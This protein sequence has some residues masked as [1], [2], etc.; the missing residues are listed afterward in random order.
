MQYPH[1]NPLAFRSFTFKE[2]FK[3]VCFK[4]ERKIYTQGIQNTQKIS[5]LPPNIHPKTSLKLSKKNL[6]IPY[7]LSIR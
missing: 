3:N 2:K 5:L 1:K 6:K 7:L 4:Q